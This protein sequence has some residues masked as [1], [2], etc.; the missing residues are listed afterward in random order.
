MRAQ[1][2]LE[3][4]PRT[5]GAVRERIVH[6]RAQLEAIVGRLTEAELTQAAPSNGWS[7][8]ERGVVE[9]RV[10]GEAGAKG[11]RA[12]ASPSRPS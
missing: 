10:R 3:T 9:L 8:K 2:A 11:R 5:I 4:Q 12:V 6:E 1:K 7:V